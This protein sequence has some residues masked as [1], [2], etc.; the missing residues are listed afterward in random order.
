[1]IVRPHLTLFFLEARHDIDCHVSFT[2]GKPGEQSISLLGT[3]RGFVMITTIANNRVAPHFFGRLL[4]TFLNSMSN[5]FA[6]ALRSSF[7]TA[8]T[9][10]VT[11]AL[12]CLVFSSAINAVRI[13][14]FNSSKRWKITTSAPLRSSSTQSLFVVG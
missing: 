12:F 5:S 6:S 10:D 8:F 11:D 7:S 3:T 4:V 13:S 1:M 9:N 2:S 14:V